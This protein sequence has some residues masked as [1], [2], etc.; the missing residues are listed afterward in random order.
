M[1]NLRIPGPIVDTLGYRR[2]WVDDERV[3]EHLV[4]AERALGRPLPEGAEVHH[5][6]ENKANNAGNNLVIC[7]D[8]AYHRLLHQRM[9]AIDVCGNANWRKCS[10]CKAY[11]D[12][13]NLYIH[14]KLCF[15]RDCYRDQ[16]RAKRNAS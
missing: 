16:K 4:V 8:A 10:V 11:D 7:P 9:R 15:H 2:V 5:V 13:A 12:P 6:D 1:P 14:R 3:Y